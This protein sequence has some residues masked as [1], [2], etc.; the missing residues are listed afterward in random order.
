MAR[1]DKKP[2]TQL[3]LDRTRV[4]SFYLSPEQKHLYDQDDYK[5]LIHLLRIF[6][7]DEFRIVQ[8]LLLKFHPLI[9]R[10]AHKYA[11][12]GIALDW[13]DLVS[14][15]K[16]SFV[17]L[18][19]RFTLESTLY[20]KTYIPLA[21]DRAVND[22]HIYDIRRRA[23][24]NAVRL[25]AATTTDRDKYI[26]EHRDILNFEETDEA[27]E[28][29]QE[30]VL[31][32]DGNIGIPPLNKTLFRQHYLENIPLPDLVASHGRPMDEIKRRVAET[33]VEVRKHLRE[34][35]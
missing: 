28:Y 9:L 34:V 10:V 16:Y 25:D 6:P 22:W 11:K 26:A 5:Y 4:L 8:Y 7:T 31:F 15:T 29:K 32:L 2:E 12:K 3:K 1:G 19:M 14:F 20:F 18:V 13:L 21:L 30:C 35:M 17:E 24:L 23:I 33:L 27:V